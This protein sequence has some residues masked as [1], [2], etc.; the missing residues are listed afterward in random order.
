MK[1][2]SSRFGL[3][4]LKAANIFRHKQKKIIEVPPGCCA[5]IFPDVSTYQEMING[6]SDAK[7]WTGY[8]YPK[9]VLKKSVFSMN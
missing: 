2:K 8:N 3:L 5:L 4:L 1:L 6:L 9:K 7:T